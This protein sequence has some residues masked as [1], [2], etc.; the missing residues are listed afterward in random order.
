MKRHTLV[1][2]HAHPDDEVV[3]TGGTLAKA[4]AAGHRVVLVVATRGEA[5]LTGAP[6]PDPEALAGRRLEELRAAAAA[7]GCA[8][9]EWLGYADSGLDRPVDDATAFARADPDIAAQR[10]AAILRSETADVLTTYDAF[11]GYGHPDHVR[12][13]EVGRRAAALASTP[14]VLEATVDRHVLLRVARVLRC[15]PGLPAGFRPARLADA[16]A[17]ADAITHCIDVRAYAAQKRAAM[18]AHAS[19]TT[20]GAGPR[21][22]AVFLRLPTPVF[23]RIFGREWFISAGRAAGHPRLDD[24]FAGLAC[25]PHEAAA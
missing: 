9:V 14:V 7:L 15:I 21:S 4:A 24:V 3:L 25:D 23:R 17:P 2:F 6:G 12:V 19:Q 1:A 8:R 5:G 13:H 20:G 22:L 18:A 10:L 11:G 16:Y